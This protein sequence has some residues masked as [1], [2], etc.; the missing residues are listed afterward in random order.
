MQKLCTAAM[1]GLSY[2]LW[3][4]I[5]RCHSLSGQNNGVCIEG[6]LNAELLFGP[7]EAKLHFKC[8]REWS[9]HVVQ[10]FLH[11]I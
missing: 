2:T 4:H 1:A 5:Y 8:V 9:T 7:W 3:H 10:E 6:P 11:C